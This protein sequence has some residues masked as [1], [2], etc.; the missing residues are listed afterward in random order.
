M[1]VGE[2]FLGNDNGDTL[3]AKADPL[4]AR[5]RQRRC[6]VGLPRARG[7]QQDGVG[8]AASG[9]RFVKVGGRHV[10]RWHA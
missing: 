10:S 9:A 7:L 4:L 6:E 1:P 5:A 3:H 8:A 2:H